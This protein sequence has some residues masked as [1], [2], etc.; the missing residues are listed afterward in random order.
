MILGLPARGLVGKESFDM[1]LRASK[2]GLVLVPLTLVLSAS[3]ATPKYQAEEGAR[4]APSTAQK[5]FT[6]GQELMINHRY[7]D[8]VEQFRLAIDEDSEFVDA[9]KNLAAAYTKMAESEAEYYED[10]LETYEDLEIIVDDDVA[11]KKN[12]AFILAKLDELQDAI[13]TYDEIIELAP[14]DCQAMGTKG[15]LHRQLAEEKTDAEQEAEVNLAL[16][17]FMMVIENCPEELAAY[18]TAGEILFSQGKTDEASAVYDQLLVKDPENVEINGRL[19]YMWYKSAEAK[20][21]AKDDAAKSDY[22]KAIP[23][24]GKVLDLDP[25]RVEYR[26]IY[27]KSLQYA[28]K[29]DDAAAQYLKIIQENPDKK[30]QYCSL[31]FLYLDSNAHDKAVEMAM[32]A[33]SEGAPQ[34]GCLYCVWGKGLEKRGSAL[35]EDFKFSQAIS[36]FTEAKAKFTLAQGDKQFGGYATKQISRQ[37]QLIERTKQIRLQ[38]QQEGGG[39]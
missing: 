32:L 21:K 23:Y 14:D 37:D 34:Q 30:D 35:V 10:A 36:T 9:Y 27:A 12:K 7:L 16:E 11:I 25:E 19:G 18:N 38:V 6:S 5:Y 1:L 4:V 33:I 22:Q 26:S 2:L 28:G 29:F 31:G 39:K 17:S 8:A 24:L 15:E 20:R 13:D 3:A